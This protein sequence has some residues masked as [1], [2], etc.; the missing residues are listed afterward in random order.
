MNPIT[1]Q[2]PKLA[3][4]AAAAVATQASAGSIDCARPAIGTGEVQACR[5]ASQ[6]VDDL[7]RFIQRT[8]GIYILY[9]Q[10]FE[11]AVRQS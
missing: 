4:L 1:K 5:A 9:I 2:L 11:N 6:G 7:R 10:D 8:R 3:F